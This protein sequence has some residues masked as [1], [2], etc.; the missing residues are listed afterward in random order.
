MK[1]MSPESAK[2]QM[3]QLLGASD[4]LYLG[5]I[6][7]VLREIARFEN[8][9]AILETWR[10]Q[11]KGKAFERLQHRVW[12]ITYRELKSCAIGCP[13]APAWWR[14]TIASLRSQSR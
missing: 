8:V 13:L 1:I 7:P 3:A 4:K 11:V 12:S 5:F 10:S 6:P 9:A 14:E 2:L